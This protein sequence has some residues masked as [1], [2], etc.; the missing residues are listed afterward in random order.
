MTVFMVSQILSFCLRAKGW[1]VSPSHAHKG[2][3]RKQDLLHVHRSSQRRKKSDALLRRRTVCYPQ[4][5][6]DLCQSSEWNPWHCWITK[7]EVPIPGNVTVFQ[8]TKCGREC[9]LEN[10][11]PQCLRAF[12]GSPS[13][14]AAWSCHHRKGIVEVERD[15]KNIH[16]HQRHNRDETN[17]LPENQNR[18]SP[19]TITQQGNTRAHDKHANCS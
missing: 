1:S 12:H 18:L 3:H 17:N 9:T 14:N 4:S 10:Y 5:E 8:C 2:C 13:L 7:H 15:A 6:H 19:I 11:Y 16:S